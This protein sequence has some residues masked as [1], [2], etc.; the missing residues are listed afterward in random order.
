MSIA[1]FEAAFMLKGSI[2]LVLNFTLFLTFQRIFLRKKAPL[3]NNLSF[4][5][6]N[7]F[8]TARDV[9]LN[10]NCSV[11]PEGV[12]FFAQNLDTLCD[13]RE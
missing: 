1:V 6:C 7:S 4:F 9:R 2:F 12:F 8:C 5:A 10:V 13:K 3:Y 11:L